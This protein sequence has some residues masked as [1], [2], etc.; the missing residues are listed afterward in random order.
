[1]T[2]RKWSNNYCLVIQQWQMVPALLNDTVRMAK[3]GI[4]KAGITVSMLQKND[5]PYHYKSWAAM[6]HRHHYGANTTYPSQTQRL[7]F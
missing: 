3:L 5:V 2:E 1:M 4:P 7:C 6:S